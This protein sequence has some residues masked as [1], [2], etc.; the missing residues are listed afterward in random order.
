MIKIYGA[1]ISPFVRKVRATLV[2]KGMQYELIPVNPFAIDDEFKKISPLGKIPVL[3]DGDVT[4]P[5]SSA[6]LAYLEK[7]HPEPALF[8]ADAA[9]YGR[10]LFY[11]EYGD[12]LVYSSIVPIFVQRFVVP[13][14]MNGTPDEQIIQEALGTLPGVCSFIEA[15]IGDNEWIVGNTF[16]V[17]DIAL[18]SAFVNLGYGG[19]SIDAQAYP[20]LTAYVARVHARPSFKALIDEEKASLGV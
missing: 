6:I 14:M 18:T 4:L 13:N 16:S 3:Q 19:E 5:D 15:E 10:A 8:P 17:A 2:E 20:K 11:E 7:V 12:T 9:D 1:N